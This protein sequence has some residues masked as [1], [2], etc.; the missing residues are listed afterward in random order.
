VGLFSAINGEQVESLK[1]H[2]DLV[3]VVGFSPVLPGYMATGSY[4]HTVKIWDLNQLAAVHT[5]QGH[6]GAVLCL[7]CLPELI[8]TGS[9]DGTI[10]LWSVKTGQCKQTLIG[11]KSWVNS[12][13]VDAKTNRLISGSSDGTVK[14]WSSSGG[15]LL[16]DLVATNAEVRSVAVSPDGQYL[17]AGLR[18]GNAKLWTTDDWKEVATLEAKADDAW[19]VAF[20]A[21]SKQLLVAAGEWNRPTEIAIWDVATRKKTGVLKHPGEVL[22]LAVSADGKFIAAGGGDKTISVWRKE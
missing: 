17:A 14:V 4:D 11:H 3:A 15:K 9:V 20:T 8:A 6:R 21:D 1:G 7:A 16:K 12:L 13:A 10:K 22:G 18:Y 5:L 2:K 19:A